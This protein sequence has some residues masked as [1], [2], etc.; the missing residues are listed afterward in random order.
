VTEVVVPNELAK[1][2]GVSRLAF[3]N[4]LRSERAAGHPLLEGHEHGRHY[5]FSCRE[6]D[7]LM[8][9]YLAAAGSTQVPGEPYRGMASAPTPTPPAAG[10]VSPAN[11]DPSLRSASPRASTAPW[12]SP[13]N[14][15]SQV[16]FS[17]DPGHRVTESWMGEDLTTL[18]DL[19]RPGLR[20]V[21]VG[22][23]PSPISVAAGH[24][25]QG[26]SGQRFLARLAQADVLDLSGDGYEDDQA[27]A[28][29]IG[30]TDAV[31]RPT[32]RADALLSGELAHGR[33]LLEA[34]LAE[35]ATPLVIFTFKKAAVTL[36]GHFD[37]HGLLQGRTL[38]GA[39]IFVMPGPME[40]AN[41]VQR[42]LRE[43]AGWWSVD[44]I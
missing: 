26:Q 25:Y 7:Q 20:A 28:Q 14:P 3:R 37:G 39:E 15:F 36:L 11:A 10:D 42:A 44:A 29:D 21:V 6:A 33:E 8:A 13:A 19:L 30:F 23:N 31:K 2:L 22:V 24:Y 5:R 40:R 16:T 17:E 1:A 34:R 32:A 38:G 12:V 4:W 35:V 43:L 18:A 9:D 27:W 41:H